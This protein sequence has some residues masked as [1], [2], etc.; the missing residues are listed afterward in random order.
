M[1]GARLALAQ[2]DRFHFARRII[3]RPADAGG[4]D[5]EAVDEAAFEALRRDGA[6]LVSWQA[7]GLSYGLPAILRD[8]LASGCNVVANGSRAALEALAREVPRLIALHVTASPAIRAGRL[9]GRYH[10]AIT[11]Y[12]LDPLGAG[13]SPLW[14]DAPF[15]SQRAPDGPEASSAVNGW[16]ASGGFAGEYVASVAGLRRAGGRRGRGGG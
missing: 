14:N 12:N 10:L 2:D 7:H 8:V 5:H 16:L 11:S 4:E 1:D 9:A 6:L 15:R 3:T 13:G